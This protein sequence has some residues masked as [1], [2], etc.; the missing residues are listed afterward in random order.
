MEE[1]H[2]G[3]SCLSQLSP[4]QPCQRHPANT[5]GLGGWE[6]TQMQAENSSSSGSAHSRE[7]AESQGAASRDRNCGKA[8]PMPPASGTAE[9]AAVPT[10]QSPPQGPQS[11][12]APHLL[13]TKAVHPPQ[14]PLPSSI[15][16]CQPPEMRRAELGCT[17][18]WQDRSWPLKILPM[19]P[20][21]P[22]QE[23][24]SWQQEQ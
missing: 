6:E 16:S 13:T 9:E 21:N 7:T 22:C 19:A 23:A 8:K 3:A 5:T 2:S 15:P 17:G 14:V 18:A 20:R 10:G 12:L 24:N 1:G 11:A 4:E